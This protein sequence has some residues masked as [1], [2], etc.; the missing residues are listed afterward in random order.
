MGEEQTAI[1][2]NSFEMPAGDVVVYATFKEKIVTYTITVE[3]NDLAAITVSPEGPAAAET[4]I[5]V[6]VVLDDADNFVVEA[7]RVSCEH[8]DLAV[9]VTDN[10][11]GTYS[12]NMPGDNVT[13]FAVVKA[14]LHGVAFSSERHW[15]TY[16]TGGDYNLALPEGIK[17]YVA[18][19]V[20]NEAVDITEV[21]Y[22]PAGVGVLLYSETAGENFLVDLYE[23][24]PVNVTSILQGSDTEQTITSGYVLYN[25]CFIRSEAGTLAAHRCYLH[26]TAVAGA[27]AMLMIGNNG[28]P[29]AIRDILAS[30]NV[31]SVKYVNLSGLTSNQPFNGINIAVVTFN[32]GTTKTV[33]VIK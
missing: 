8:V 15:A 27:P 23:G 26:S 7:V 13:V 28:V 9:Q 20:E 12:F 14:K 31:A 16:F 19:K 11:D 32:D 24:T 17:A 25:D 22:I 10:G 6:T 4:P 33:K 2:G 30:G 29:T 5:T 18:N 3:D 1:T 21:G